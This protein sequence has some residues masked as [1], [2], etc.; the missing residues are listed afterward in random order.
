MRLVPPSLTLAVFY[1]RNLMIKRLTTI[2]VALAV[3]LVTAAGGVAFA[4]SA[5]STHRTA[6]HKAAVH[7]RTAKAAAGESIGEAQEQSGEE[8]TSDGPGGHEDPAGGE[9]D[10]QFEG[11]E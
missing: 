8:A 3:A 9:V 5:T 1:E 4:Q 10:H 2:A 6:V 11:E 7:H